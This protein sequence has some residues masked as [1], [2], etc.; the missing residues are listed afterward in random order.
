MKKGRKTEEVAERQAVARVGLEPLSG[1][2]PPRPPEQKKELEGTRARGTTSIGSA[3]GLGPAVGPLPR[4]SGAL[5]DALRLV[6]MRG[7]RIEG[8]M[9][10]AAGRGRGNAPSPRSRGRSSSW[11]SLQINCHTVWLEA[12]AG[13][14]EVCGNGRESSS[15]QRPRRV[16]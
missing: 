5:L 13:G 8:R 1:F 10:A 16:T 7:S 11:A 6:G 15:F 9:A 14:F 2:A 4:P 12:G 3:C